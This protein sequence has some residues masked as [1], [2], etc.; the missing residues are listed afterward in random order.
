MM[1]GTLRVRRATIVLGVLLLTTGCR[2]VRVD[3]DCRLL[4]DHDQLHRLDGPTYVIRGPNEA[5]EASLAFQET[6]DLLARGLA[7]ER[8]DLTRV[9]LEAPA[10]LMISIAYQVVDR[11]TAVESY[12]VYGHES[13]FAF[14]YGGPIHHYHGY[15]PVGAHVE[16]VH[17][18][19]AHRLFLT[20]WVP[21]E[22]RPADR[23][24]LWEGYCDHAGPER[25]LKA[26]LPYL[27]AAIVPYYG[28]PT[29][30]LERIKF[31]RDDER[32]EPLL[33][34]DAS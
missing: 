19:F 32:V 2:H 33:R 12:P 13:G 20:A 4:G 18:G 17:L 29:D 3:V 24:V 1:T 21:D 11:G 14:S 16:S 25:S 10:H 22:S 31:D 30:D 15:G 34:R 26:T 27:V 5:E 8:P 9:A 7:A 23:L 6:A 28:R